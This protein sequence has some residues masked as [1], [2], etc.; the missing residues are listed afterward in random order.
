MNQLIQFPETM[1]VLLQTAMLALAAVFL[2]LTL[3][4]WLLPQP[5]RQTVTAVDS[6]P[7]GSLAARSSVEPGASYS[8]LRAVMSG[9]SPPNDCQLAV[10][11]RPAAWKN[12]DTD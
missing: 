11:E 7:G 9:E 2:L 10:R 1:P 3:I 8:G 4:L 5:L 12:A 6:A